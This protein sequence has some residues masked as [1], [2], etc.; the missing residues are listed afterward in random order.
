MPRS[1]SRPDEVADVAGRRAPPRTHRRRGPSRAGGRIVARVV[2]AAVYGYWSA[3]TSRPSA[4]AA[5]SRATASPARPQT[6]RAPH[7]RC[8]T[9]SRAGRRPPPGPPRSTRRA[10]RTARRSRCACASRTGRRAGPPPRRAPRSRPARRACPARRSGRTTARTRRRRARPRPRRPSPTAPR[11][12]RGRA[13]A[14]I[15]DAADRAVPDEERDVRPERLLLD[16]VE[17]LG[18]RPPARD[19]PVRAQRQLDELAAAV[20][21]RR[22][23]CRRSCPTAGS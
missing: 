3:A 8:E 17:V 16:P 1:I 19:Q 9:W 11:R 6:D 12:S 14:P 20:G 5:S 13:S 22:E 7:L 15:T 18:E 23:A 4:R 10:R 21:D 2:A